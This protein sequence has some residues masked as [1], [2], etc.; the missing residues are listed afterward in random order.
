VS[1]PRGHAA[2]ARNVAPNLGA[3]LAVLTS[4][5][6][7]LVACK[8]S[9]PGA[10]LAASSEASKA[11]EAASALGS[12][13][14]APAGVP[15]RLKA[16]RSAEDRRDLAAITE[17]DV[18]SS[19]VSVRR[20]A[21]RALARIASDEARPALLRLLSDED[22]EA[23]SLAAYGLGWTCAGHE[24]ENVAA[25]VA[26]AAT[27]PLPPSPSSSPGS[28]GSAGSASSAGSPASPASAGSPGSSGGAPSSAAAKPKAAPTEA[29]RF[30]PLSASARA[31]GRC[32]SVEAEATLVSWLRGPRARAV[33]AALG[34]GD[35]ASRRKMADDSL[36]ALSLAAAG[37]PG[38]APIDEALFAFGRADLPSPAVAARV[39]EVAT[40]R[41]SVTGAA[42]GEGR[43]LAIRALG[44]TNGEAA[45][46]LGRV[47]ASPDAFRDVER[48]EAAK[49]LGRLGDK[50]QKA[51]V[52][53][54]PQLTPGTDAMSLAGLVSDAFGPRSAALDAITSPPARAALEPLA[55]LAKL[56]LPDGTPPAS[57]TR[58]VVHLRCAA[59]RLLAPPGSLDDALVA[60]CDP[61]DGGEEGALARLWVLARR[62]LD[63]ARRKAAFRAFFASPSARVRTLAFEQLAAHRELPEGDAHQLVA[64]GLR[65][66]HPGTVAAAAQALVTRPDLASQPEAPGR[67]SPVE[68]ALLAA[69]ERPFAPDDVE[70][71]ATLASAAGAAHI[72]SAR[73]H[74]DRLCQSF[75]PTL[76]AHAQG[77]LSLLG[78][79]AARCRSSP[80]RPDP[81]PE[82]AHVPSGKPR[83]VLDTD[84]GE[85]SLELDPLLAPAAVT[86]LLDLASAGFFDDMAIH[87]VV[88]GFVVQF[89]DR[90]GDGTGGAG[91][92]ALRCET[93][94]V[95]FRALSI[96]LALAGRDTGSSQFF[97]TL[98]RAPHLDGEYPLLGQASGDWAAV[99]EGDRIRK[100]RLAP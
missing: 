51:L 16:L 52:D 14:S 6:L 75:S 18:T 15:A 86:R 3:L 13:T 91:K 24:E 28:P 73:K 93:L 40:Q 57:I 48:A 65:S 34:L 36:V 25:L 78:D 95:P 79:K 10:G 33:P 74:L 2:P 27:L 11:H 89:G 81:A 1:A 99:A 72:T 100:T 70:T 82:L 67:P 32:A 4:S 50:G 38:S 9:P 85:L 69:L 26:R 30:D 63:G 88:P 71:V 31:L 8:R 55:A 47:L 46:T 37:S 41:L 59:A 22:P 96:G 87:R 5:A 21:A 19:D 54:L 58:R 17:A 35:I 39:R 94:P 20:A 12:A 68:V 90:A 61:A 43:V 92:D 29:P 66:K 44:R 62:P 53:A 83:L 77:A 49:A 80:P 97:V 42:G 76:R 98:S 64:Q 7:L 45:E 60:A 23:C 56:P 84:A